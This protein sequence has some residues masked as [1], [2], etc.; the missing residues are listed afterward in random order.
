MR[1]CTSVEYIRHVS[2][3]TA[4]SAPFRATWG[5]MT[6]LYRVMLYCAHDQ[7]QEG[8]RPSPQVGTVKVAVLMLAHSMDELLENRVRSLTVLISMG[9]LEFFTISIFGGRCQKKSM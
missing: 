1:N 2:R 6:H 4:L 9:V 3:I 8:T 5:K 7:A